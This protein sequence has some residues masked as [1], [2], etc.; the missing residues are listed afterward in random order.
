M[1]SAPILV[2]YSFRPWLLICRDVECQRIRSGS[3]GQGTAQKKER[4]NK[5]WPAGYCG[6]ILCAFDE[7]QKITKKRLFRLHVACYALSTR[8]QI[9]VTGDCFSWIP[10]I[11]VAAICGQTSD[12]SI[13]FS[14][15]T[16]LIAGKR[17]IHSR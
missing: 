7:S 4:L 16:L 3:A 14:A 17:T 8:K 2:H 6:V 5:Q 10:K 15:R 12:A 13:L 1:E 9:T 11:F